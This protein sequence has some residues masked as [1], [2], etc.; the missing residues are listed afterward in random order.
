MS[1][2]P[3]CEGAGGWCQQCERGDDCVC[4]VT[5]EGPEWN[6]CTE[7]KGDGRLN[8]NNPKRNVTYWENQADMMRK[9]RRRA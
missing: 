8:P 9:R 7:C 6:R 1:K 3:K 4:P 2:C 5:P